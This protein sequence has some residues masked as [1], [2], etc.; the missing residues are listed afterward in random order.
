MARTKHHLVIFI[1]NRINTMGLGWYWEYLSGE[2]K[3]YSYA[4]QVQNL[5]DEHELSIRVA[6]DE[7][8]AEIVEKYK[9]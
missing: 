2:I 7:E 5:R 6:T 4:T 8:F 9:G 3:P 1:G